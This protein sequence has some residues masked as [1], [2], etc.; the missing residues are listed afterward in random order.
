MTPQK[1]TVKQ[2]EWGNW[3]LERSKELKGVKQCSERENKITGTRV[4]YSN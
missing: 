3:I 2:L 4:E 1:N